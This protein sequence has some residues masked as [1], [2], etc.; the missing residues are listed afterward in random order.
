MLWAKNATILF[1]VFLKA[2]RFSAILFNPFA[3]PLCTCWCCV[4]TTCFGHHATIIRYVH[5]IILTG[6]QT[7][8]DASIHY[9]KGVHP[10]TYPMGTGGS[11]PGVKRPGR[12]ADHSPPASAEVKKMWIYTP[13]PPHAFMAWCLIIVKHRRQLLP[14]FETEG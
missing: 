7:K 11:F 14:M 1:F 6:P 13:T 10:T 12:E 8:Q 2:L 9:G 4:S 3:L 5:A